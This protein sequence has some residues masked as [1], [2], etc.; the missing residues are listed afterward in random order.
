[1]Q[2][3]F[4]RN[5]LL[6]RACMRVA[7]HIR[8]LWEE[9]RSSDTRL[10]ESFFIPDAFTVVGQSAALTDGKPHREHVVPRLVVVG[11]CHRLLAT[12]ATD[13]NIADVI[14]D[15]VKIVLISQEER[16]RLDSSRN[17][18]LKQTMPKGWRFGDD[19]YARLHAAGIEW[20]PL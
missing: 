1:V 4:S 13:R 10:L 20:K 12:G 7:M 16:L 18:G 11:E 17:L 3:D 6:D 15:N 9:K 8:G 14:R 5:E 2:R 19:I